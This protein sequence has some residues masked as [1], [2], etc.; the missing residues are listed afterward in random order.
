MTKTGFIIPVYK[1][2]KQVLAIDKQFQYDLH[3]VGMFK[4]NKDEEFVAILNEH[5]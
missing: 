3:Y 1:F 5:F 4:K 2:Y